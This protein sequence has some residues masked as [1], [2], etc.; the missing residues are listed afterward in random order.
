MS[1]WRNVTHQEVRIL[2]R[3]VNDG[4]APVVAPYVR[5]QVRDPFSINIVGISSREPTAPLQL[6][7]ET[8]QPGSVTLIGRTDFTIYAGAQ[9]EI[10]QLTAMIKGSMTVPQCQVHFSI[11]SAGSGPVQGVIGIPSQ[12][13]AKLLRRPVEPD[14]RE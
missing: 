14:E 3:L 7:P 13:I 5:V 6:V 9:F 12:E 2:L 1:Y 8:S 11:T 4:P 10:L